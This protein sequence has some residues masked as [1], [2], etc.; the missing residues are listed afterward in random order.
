MNRE[1]IL[2]WRKIYLR[3][4]QS[5]P[6]MKGS[7]SQFQLII[8]ISLDRAIFPLPPLLALCDHYTLSSWDYERAGFKNSVLLFHPYCLVIPTEGMFLKILL[9]HFFWSIQGSSFLSSPV[10]GNH[11]PHWLVCKIWLHSH[12]NH[13]NPEDGGSMFL[14]NICICPQNRCHDSEDYS[15]TLL[16]VLWKFLSCVDITE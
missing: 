3:K 11:I 13:C 14:W 4:G 8:P 12:T 5:C 7:F 15:L 2:F 6:D 1:K 16:N 9:C 10:Q